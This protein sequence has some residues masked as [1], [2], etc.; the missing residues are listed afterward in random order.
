[1]SKKKNKEILESILR[2]N[3]LGYTKDAI[4]SKMLEQEVAGQRIFYVW[5]KQHG[6]SIDPESMD[7]NQSDGIV[8]N[9]IIECKLDENEGG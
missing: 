4:V 8:G 1:M 7:K 6:Y 3:L 5:L 9:T 2:E